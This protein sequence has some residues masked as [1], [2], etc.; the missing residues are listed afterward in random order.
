MEIEHREHEG[1]KYTLQQ[2]KWGL[3]LR[4]HHKLT[5]DYIFET[6]TI[7]LI[8]DAERKITHLKTEGFLKLS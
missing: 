7:K 6:G 1:I 3:E 8:G 2:G 4:I 5:D